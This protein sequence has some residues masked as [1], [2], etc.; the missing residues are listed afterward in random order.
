MSSGKGRNGLL[1]KRKARGDRT[2]M[3]EVEVWPEQSSSVTPRCCAF[4]SPAFRWS[5]F[6][7]EGLLDLTKLHFTLH[8]RQ[9]LS[10]HYPSLFFQNFYNHL[11]LSFL[12][13][14]VFIT[15]FPSLERFLRALNILSSVWW[16]L[17]ICWMIKRKTT[18]RPQSKRKAR[19]ILRNKTRHLGLVNDNGLQWILPPAIHALM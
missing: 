9:S 6:P 8:F 16:C 7:S 3:T 18:Q 1:T 17:N 12:V 19:C 5:A 13:L 2:V 4:S 11:K 14:H 15:C 10:P